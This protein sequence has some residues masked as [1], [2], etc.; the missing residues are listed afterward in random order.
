MKVN[1]PV[2]VGVP[3]IT[4]EEFMLNPLGREPSTIVHV[5]GVDPEAISV[6]GK[7][8]VML[9]VVIFGGVLISD[10]G[11]TGPLPL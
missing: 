5:I 6:N 7:T 11:V 10:G 4:P 8:E 2:C 1:V 3:V 9:V